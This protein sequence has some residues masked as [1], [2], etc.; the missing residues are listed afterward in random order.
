M[1]LSVQIFFNMKYPNIFYLKY[2]LNIFC[3]SQVTE[4]HNKVKAVVV[5][6]P[7][8]ECDLEPI[9]VCKHVTKMIPQLR[10]V[11]ECVNVPKEVCGMSKVK[12]TKVTIPQIQNWCI[13]HDGVGFVPDETT[14]EV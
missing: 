12:P 2:L 11:K 9:R 5:S 3:I 6:K 10:A 7:Q 8:E 13:N 4:C 1:K 14:T